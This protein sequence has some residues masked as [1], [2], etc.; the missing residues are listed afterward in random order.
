[1]VL[2]AAHLEGYLE[3]LVTEAIDALVAQ[4]TPAEQLPLILRSIHV[5]E[6]LRQIEPVKDRNARAQKIERM[7]ATESALWS[8]GTPITAKMVRAKAVC[9]EMSNPGSREVRQ[10]LEIIGVDIDAYLSA[11][12]QKDLLGR[13]NGLVGRRNAV[14]HGEATASATAGDVDDYLVLV[15]DLGRE[16]DDAVAISV[17][18]ICGSPTLP[19]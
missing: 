8:S 12:G 7:F 13:V 19:W 2:L 17:Q 4:A 15:E 5:E 18:D 9:L 6:H 1:L 14:A 10:F 3:D 16:V 11:Q